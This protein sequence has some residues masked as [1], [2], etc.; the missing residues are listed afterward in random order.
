VYSSYVLS[1][2]PAL[3]NTIITFNNNK[4]GGDVATFRKVQ[5]AWETLRQSHEDGRTDFFSSAACATENAAGYETTF[6]NFDGTTAPSWEFY[7]SA[8][9]EDQPINL[10]ELAKSGRS[11]CANTSKNPKLAKCV[12]AVPAEVG[13]KEGGDDD[14]EGGSSAL[15]QKY[16]MNSSGKYLIAKGEIRVGTYNDVSGTYTWFRHLR[17]R[18]NTPPRTRNTRH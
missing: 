15:S 5:A 11:A 7:Y 6:D 16:P 3:C 1:N 4:K 9:E 14:D 8:A 12:P 2:I 13:A 18:Q 10:I 17:V